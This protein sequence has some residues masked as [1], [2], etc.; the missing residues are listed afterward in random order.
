[1]TWLAGSRKRDTA[2]RAQHV[3][4][5]LASTVATGLA[6]MAI[7]SGEPTEER[8]QPGEIVCFMTSQSPALVNYYTCT[9]MADTF[10]F[11]LELFFLTNPSLKRDCSNIQP[12][13]EYCITG[14][15]LQYTISRSV[16]KMPY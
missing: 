1:V 15:K 6:A 3:D 10:E 7:P 4:I 12:L 9:E 2:S 11:P 16:S 14:C 13:T 8:V 5:Q